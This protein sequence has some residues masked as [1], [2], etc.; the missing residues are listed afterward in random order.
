VSIP[1]NTLRRSLHLKT[2]FVPRCKHI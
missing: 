2:Q 1:L